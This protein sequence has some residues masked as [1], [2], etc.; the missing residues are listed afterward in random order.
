[1]IENNRALV[2]LVEG[3]QIEARRPGIVGRTNE[4]PEKDCHD[5]DLDERN[6]KPLAKARPRFS[7]WRLGLAMRGTGFRLGHLSN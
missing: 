3:F 5:A 6:Y 2:Q 7:C 1:M 4:A